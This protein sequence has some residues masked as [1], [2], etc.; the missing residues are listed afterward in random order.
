MNIHN[1]KEQIKQLLLGYSHFMPSFSQAGE[2]MILRSIFRRINNGFFVDIGAYDPVVCSNTWFI[3]KFRGWTGINIE[4]NPT[5]FAAFK[6]Q[7]PKDINLNIGISEKPQELDYYMIDKL[8][9]MNTFSEEFIRYSKLENDVSRVMKIPTDTLKNVLDK[10]NPTNR[11][12]DIMN[13]DVEGIDM[14]VLNSN[15][16]NKYVPKCIVIEVDNDKIFN[17]EIPAF[18]K[19]KGYSLKGLTPV[20]TLLNASCIYLHDE[21][22]KDFNNY[23][24]EIK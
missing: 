13:I 1:L 5:N 17:G 11:P 16:W 4:P 18:L 15:D 22:M 20:N 23:H 14:Q 3:Y 2:D 9:A 24:P 6:K 10:H 19:E 12:I 21:L 7:R 8:P